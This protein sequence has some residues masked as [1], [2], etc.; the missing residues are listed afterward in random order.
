MTEEMNKEYLQMLRKR[1]PEFDM[2][3]HINKSNVEHIE[4]LENKVIEL[5]RLIDNIEREIEYTCCG[6]EITGEIK[7]IGLCPKCLEH[8]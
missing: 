1:I 7:D 5:E 6:V 4:Y 2:A 8:I 3:M